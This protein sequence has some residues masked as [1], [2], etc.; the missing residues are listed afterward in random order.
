MRH[1]IVNIG[2]EFGA[3]GLAI[4]KKLAGELALN[5]TTASL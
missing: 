3:L 1:F 2:R 5:I 4:G